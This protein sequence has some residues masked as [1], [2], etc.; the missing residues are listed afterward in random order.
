MVSSANARLADAFDRVMVLAPMPT[1]YGTIPGVE[2]DVAAMQLTAMVHLS[3][4]DEESV[5][6][7]GPN[8]YDP[9]RR[10]PAA[11]AGRLQGIRLAPKINEMW[12]D[13]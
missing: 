13:I 6:A 4:P 11:D 5:L 2:D 7:I 9:D 1:G 3:T 12:D 8:P 10:G